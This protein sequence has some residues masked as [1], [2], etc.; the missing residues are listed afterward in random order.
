MNKYK[1]LSLILG[2]LLFAFSSV[3]IKYVNIIFTGNFR[4]LIGSILFLISFLFCGL[5]NKIKIKEF[6]LFYIFNIWIFCTI[7]WS[8]EIRVSLYKSIAYFI[9]CTSCLISSYHL[10]YKNKI[11]DSLNFMIPVF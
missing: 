4:W 8:E 5:L 9:V 10:S 7:I 2:I 1:I 3:S 11:K 6:F